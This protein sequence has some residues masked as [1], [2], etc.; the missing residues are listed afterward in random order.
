MGSLG[1]IPRRRNGSSLFRGRGGGGEDVLEN[2]SEVVVV[3]VVVVE[4][5]V[6][7]LCFTWR[8]ANDGRT[9]DDDD[10]G[11]ANRALEMNTLLLEN[12]THTPLLGLD[13]LPLIATGAAMTS[14]HN[15]KTGAEYLVDFMFVRLFT[16]RT[17]LETPQYTMV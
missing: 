13:E 8:F 16:T 11:S 15:C 1:S 7:L 6:V 14:A 10:V 5:V 4:E 9:S 3:V 17:S 2:W 12:A